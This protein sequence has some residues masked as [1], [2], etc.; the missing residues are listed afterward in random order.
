MA[1]NFSTFKDGVEKVE[2]WL[3]QEFSGIRT[4]SAT[5]TL[6]DGVKVDS[7]GTKTAISHV[8]SIG[9]EDART[10]RITPWD[11]GLLKDIESALHAADLG[12][13]VSVDDQ[14]IRIGFPELTTERR[15]LLIKSAK[16]KLEKARI[17][18]RSEREQTW[19]D[20]QEKQKDGEISEDEK[21]SLKED[22]QKHVDEAGKK[23]DAMFDRKEAQ[24]NE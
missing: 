13:S 4:G 3:A 23:F 2:E 16:D 19:N 8:A 21:F 7:Y 5:P 22:L 24:I 18:L 9:T 12:V 14:G 20:I 11:K 6:L 17:S 10:L 1:Y 15:V